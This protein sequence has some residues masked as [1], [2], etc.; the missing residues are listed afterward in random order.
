MQTY[1]LK[2]YSKI[3]QEKQKRKIVK[4]HKKQYELIRRK[5]SLT[6]VLSIFTW[7][8]KTWFQIERIHHVYTVYWMGLGQWWQRDSERRTF[9]ATI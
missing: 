1:I 5:F 6:Y 2:V 7:K 9:F 4:S 8:R 3:I